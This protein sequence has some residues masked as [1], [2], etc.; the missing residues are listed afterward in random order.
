LPEHAQLKLYKQE[1]VLLK[2]LEFL[3]L[4]D[5]YN[6]GALWMVSFV[7][8]SSNLNF[9][10][11]CFRMYLQDA[12]RPQLVSSGT[13]DYFQSAYY[14]DS[15]VFHFSE[16]GLTHFNETAGQVSAYKVHNYDSLFFKQG[17]FRFVWRNGD[18]IDD[19]GFKCADTGTPAGNPQHSNV[20]VCAWV[21]EW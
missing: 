3:T 14:F 1:N 4:V 21:Y 5:T 8:K 7:A 9:L 2:P 18:V 10:E 20:T 13:E 12:S 11:G 19:H 15:G 6:H 17:G 16:A